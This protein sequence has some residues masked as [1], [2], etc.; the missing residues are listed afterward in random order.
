MFGKRE[1]RMVIKARF[2][3]GWMNDKAS[4]HCQRQKVICGRHF[5]KQRYFGSR[6]IVHCALYA[7]RLGGHVRVAGEI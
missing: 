2:F 7:N 6:S 1:E 4:V 3:C 5:S